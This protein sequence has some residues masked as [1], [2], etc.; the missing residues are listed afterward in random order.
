VGAIRIEPGESGWLV[1]RFPY[2]PDGVAKIKAVP[3]PP[4]AS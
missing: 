3:G 2:S 4:L 1:V